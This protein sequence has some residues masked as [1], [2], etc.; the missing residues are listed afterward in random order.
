MLQFPQAALRQVSGAAA[1]DFFAYFFRQTV[2]VMRTVT[3]GE[4][5][6]MIYSKHAHEVTEFYECLTCNNYSTVSELGLIR[7]PW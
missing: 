2:G 3:L 7:L 5:V 1:L 4:I 6:V